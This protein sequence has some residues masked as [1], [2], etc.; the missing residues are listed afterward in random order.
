MDVVISLAN[1]TSVGPLKD[2]YV[3]KLLIKII[4]R[5]TKSLIN[6]ILKELLAGISVLVEA[7]VLAKLNSGLGSTVA[8]RAL[9]VMPCREVSA[10]RGPICLGTSGTNI[11]APAVF[12]VHTMRL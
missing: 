6:S 5:Y 12:S 4:N 3:T 10:A 2:S 7:L 9:L 8:W 1:N 11:N